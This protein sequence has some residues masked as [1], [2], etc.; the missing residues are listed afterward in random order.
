MKA[1]NCDGP[2]VGLVDTIIGIL[3]ARGVHATFFVIGNEAAR[4]PN[5]GAALVRAGHELGNHSWSH[6]HMAFKSS[7]RIRDEVE[8]TDSVI[9]SMGYKG[10]IYFRPPYGFKLVSLPRYLSRTN[11]ETIM[12]DVEPDTYADVAATS[13][14]IVRHVL[15]RVRPGSI[16]VLHVW[17]PSRATSLH[18]VGPLIDSLHARGF[19]VGTVGDLLANKTR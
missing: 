3:G 13:Q 10:R 15:D 9:R 4:S 11:R 8:R 7:G 2:V 17:Y 14:G 12:W 16:I 6:Q 19:R 1:I 18:A 5:V